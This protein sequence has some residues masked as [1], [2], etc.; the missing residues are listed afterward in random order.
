LKNGLPLAGEWT[1]NANGTYNTDLGNIS[2]GK[3]P[4]NPLDYKFVIDVGTAASQG[5][6]IR[7][8]GNELRLLADNP[9][10]EIGSNTGTI[11]F[12]HTNSGFNNLVCGKITTKVLEVA[13]DYVFEKDYNLMSLQEIEEYVLVNKHLPDVPTGKEINKNGINLGDM[14]L[15]L[16]KKIEE[17]TLYV[18]E[19]KKSNDLMVEEISKSKKP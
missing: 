12:W 14:S 3:I 17:L 6:A 1:T 9:G 4:T 10:V 15:I 19:L 16:L 7:G 18:I 8:K 11:T 2:I 5:M 13:P